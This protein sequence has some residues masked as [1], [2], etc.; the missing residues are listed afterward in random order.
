MFIWSESSVGLKE[1]RETRQFTLASAAFPRPSA[2]G[3]TVFCTD[4][5]SPSPRLL[6]LQVTPR[7]PSNFGFKNHF[8]LIFYGEH[9]R[10]SEFN[11]SRS[12]NTPGVGCLLTYLTKL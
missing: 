11:L 12:F 10:L 6:S 9:G 4:L 7:K 3:P 1:G 2:C 5:S 8:D